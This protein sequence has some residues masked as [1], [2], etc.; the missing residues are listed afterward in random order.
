MLYRHPKN[1]MNPPEKVGSTMLLHTTGVDLATSFAMT[2]PKINAMA[3]CS[4]NLFSDTDKK[5]HTRVVGSKGY[6]NLSYPARNPPPCANHFSEIIVQGHTSR[7]QSYIIR[8]LKEPLT[9]RSEFHPDKVIDM[10]FGGFGLYW[11]ADEVARCLK[12]KFSS[13]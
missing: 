11:E 5:Q 10:S 7:P 9:D 6:V 2:F 4:T 12:G 13:P 3:Y 1:N 8:K